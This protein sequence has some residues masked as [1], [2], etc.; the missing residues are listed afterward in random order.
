VVFTWTGATLGTGSFTASGSFAVSVGAVERSCRE[1]ATGSGEATA[2]G[3]GEATATGS[4]EATATGTGELRKN[5]RQG[6]QNARAKGTH[7]ACGKRGRSR[8]RDAS[9]GVA[10][11]GTGTA[12]ESADS[13][14]EI[15]AVARSS[16]EIVATPDKSEITFTGVSVD[17]RE[18]QTQGIYLY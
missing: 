1:S 8:E 6:R 16:T 3:S 4:G 9:E 10:S 12:G 15:A 17:K 11:E 7:A 18:K 2:T 13:A 14:T 5:G